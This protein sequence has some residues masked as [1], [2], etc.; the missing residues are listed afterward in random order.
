MLAL[1]RHSNGT[2]FVLDV[3]MHVETGITLK[4]PP[5]ITYG[6]TIPPD[7]QDR[8]ADGKN[9]ETLIEIS[10]VGHSHDDEDNGVQNMTFQFPLEIKKIDKDIRARVHAKHTDH[11]HDGTSGSHY[12]DPDRP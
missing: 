11:D 1:W 9:M 6:S 3:L 12:G 4:S 7:P 10:L 8:Y 5:I 2:H